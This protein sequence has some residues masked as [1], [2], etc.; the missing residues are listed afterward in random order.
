MHK[1]TMIA[2]KAAVQGAQAIM[3]VYE[4]DDFEVRFKNDSYNFV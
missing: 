3:K 4:K 2:L 1:L